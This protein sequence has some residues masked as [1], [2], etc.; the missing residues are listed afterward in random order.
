MTQHSRHTHTHKPYPSTDTGAGR[1]GSSPNWGT[2]PWHNMADK[3]KKNIPLLTQVWAQ[4]FS[5]LGGTNT[6]N[7]KNIPL[8][9]SADTGVGPALFLG[10]LCYDTKW[11]GTK[12]KKTS[13]S[14]PLLTQVWA[15]PSSLGV[16][17][18]DITWQV[19]KTQKTSLSIPLLTQ[20]WVGPALTSLAMTQDDSY[21]T[22]TTGNSN[23]L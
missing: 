11:R 14:I 4:L 3:N 18:Y 6:K 10:V 16:L 21:P 5:S 2:L 1:P 15:Q 22:L 12:N 8:H 19:Q 23:H 20:V 9:P 17:C 7:T 13:L